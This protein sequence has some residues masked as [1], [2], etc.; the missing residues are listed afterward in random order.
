MNDN[1]DCFRLGE[2]CDRKFTHGKAR[3]RQNGGWDC[4]QVGSEEKYGCV[5]KRDGRKSK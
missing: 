1:L 3:K 4:V 2:L 5:T